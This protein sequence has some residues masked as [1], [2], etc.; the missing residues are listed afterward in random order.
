MLL[1]RTQSQ[2]SSY[3]L[4]AYYLPGR[5][6]LDLIPAPT[7][8]Q[9]ITGVTYRDKQTFNGNCEFQCN[10]YVGG[11][12]STEGTCNLH[13]ERPPALGGDSSKPALRQQRIM[14]PT[15]SN[16]WVK[17]DMNDINSD[18]WLHKHLNSSI[19]SQIHY[20]ERLVCTLNPGVHVGAS[21]HVWWHQ[22][23]LLIL[24]PL[25]GHCVLPR[26]KETAQEQPWRTWQTTEGIHW[27]SKY[28]RSKF[29]C[30]FHH[31]NYWLGRSYGS[32]MIYMNT[33]TQAASLGHCPVA[34]ISVFICQWF[35]CC[36]WSVYHVTIK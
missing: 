32:K 4:A 1:N 15:M 22:H 14:P 12:Q 19:S 3:N 27:A 6:E 33:K 34:T 17:I 9:F 16:I 28:P 11:S 8:R 21:R 2:T 36:G 5:G 31:L 30:G 20:T 26:H 10:L 35:W 18:A 25:A 24:V 29:G 13:T 7:A 23:T